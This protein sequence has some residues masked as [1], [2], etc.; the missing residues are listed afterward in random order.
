MD[1][2]FSA[3][4]D[5]L[6]ASVRAF[7]DAEAPIAYVRRMAEHDE[8]GITP[9]VWAAIV[10]LGWTALLVP[11]PHGGLGLGIIDAVVVQEEMGRAL[12]PG[13][14]FSSAILATL[15]AG[16]LGLGERLEALA[17]GTQRGTV[18][19]DEA[20]H[21]DPLER[22]RV[23][24]TGRGSRYRLEGVKPMV[25]DGHRA[26][27]VLVPAR[28]RDGLQTFLVEQPQQH[29]P[30]QLAP[31]LDITRKFAR[32][33]FDGTRATLV[34]PPGDHSAIWRRVADDAAVLLAAE[35]IGVSEAA[36][37]LALDYAQARE[38][39][40]K[41]LSKFQ[42]TRHKAV[43][44]LREI[45]I[46]RVGVYYAAW[47]SAVDAPDREIAAAMAKSQTAGAA[48]Y[49]TAECIQVH[50]GVGYTWENDSH[51]YL[52]RAKVDD[53]LLGAQDWQ[54]ARVAD[55]YFATL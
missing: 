18:A 42:V 29:G 47:A 38:V 32:L 25:L 48:N 34:G 17:A 33:E 11:E 36:N 22:I 4:Q 15:A 23:R 46:A 30:A 28:T 51:L 10:E 7:L 43:D 52:R 8:A 12:F 45:E 44:M 27:W 21:G 13:P 35:L 53:L 50:G 14:Y 49:V 20:G 37:A 26:D 39:F 41:P 9:E 24:A 19:I 54:R 55:D 16:A 2:V 40:G 5:A 6:R 31:A 1:F 3:D